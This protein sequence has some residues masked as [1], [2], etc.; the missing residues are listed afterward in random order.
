MLDDSMVSRVHMCLLTYVLMRS[1]VYLLTCFLDYL[2]TCTFY[3][4][5][6]F[7]EKV[8]KPKTSGEDLCYNF[9]IQNVAA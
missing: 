4:S 3:Y 7:T 6:F 1:L 9:S 8:N 2:F 5:T